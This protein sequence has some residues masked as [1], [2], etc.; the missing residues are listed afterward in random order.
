MAYPCRTLSEPCRRFSEITAAIGCWTAE[1]PA[2]WPTPTNHSHSRAVGR[3]WLSPRP[4]LAGQ[5]IALSQS[6]RSMLLD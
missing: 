4:L 1:S 5:A 2:G 6:Q 3:G